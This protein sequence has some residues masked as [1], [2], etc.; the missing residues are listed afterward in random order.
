MSDIKIREEKI[1]AKRMQTPRREF[2]KEISSRLSLLYYKNS[3][4][5][6]RYPETDRVKGVM[7]FK[8]FEEMDSSQFWIEFDANKSF[9]ENYFALIKNM[10]IPNLIH[11]SNTENASFSDVILL[12][13]NVY[14]SN[15]VITDCENVLY[16]LNVKEYSKN[17]INSIQV[18][19]NSENIY[20]SKWVIES[21][22]IFYSKYIYNSSNIR[23]STNLAWCSEC[24]LC[25]DL[26][27][28]SYC[29]KNKKYEKAEYQRMK[30]H[31]LH[32]KSKFLWY[33]KDATNIWANF[34]SANV[35]GNFVQ[36]SENV[37]NWYY[38]YQL[39]DCRN[40]LL[41][42]WIGTNTNMCDVVSGGSGTNSDFFGMISC[43]ANA[44]NLYTSSN[45]TWSSSVFYSYFLRDCSYCIGCV[46][47]K[48]KSFCIL[49]KEYTK[50]ERFT[51]V[52]KIFEQMDK[53][54]TL[55][56][57]FPWWMNPFYFNDTAAYLI[58]DTFTKEEVAQEWYL[59]RDNEIKVDIPQWARM[60]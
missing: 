7:P 13:K 44:Q 30:E 16:S 10:D 25:N 11:Y 60:S 54:W 43:W 39:K 32:E 28:Q 22:K 4:L 49:N 19:N 46:G 41:F 33:Y 58:D 29:I 26:E 42:G 55:W 53:D 34:G 40:I 2:L 45:V 1:K 20:F 21:F 8:E 5:V 17:V 14:L 47:L 57:F 23:F 31:I 6:S 59:R 48:N 35:K 37:E 12:S 27:N 3:G 51:L 24:I 56:Q 15:T 38:G 18:R 36:H 52:N 9:F 50:E